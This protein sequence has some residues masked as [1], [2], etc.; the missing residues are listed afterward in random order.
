M[1]TT[2]QNIGTLLL[3]EYDGL[4]RLVLL[5][6]EEQKFI[7]DRRSEPLTELLVKIEDQL[8]HIQQ[9]QSQR[10]AAL[11]KILGEIP[12]TKETGLV[13]QIKQLPPSLVEGNI[14]IAQL[15]ETEIQMVHELTFQN[16]VLLSH[17]V[18]FLE[19]VLAP[20]IDSQRELTT[21]SKD[22]LVQKGNKPQTTFQAVA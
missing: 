10:K 11:H 6:K 1:S 8:A 2:T 17:S 13:A 4:S 15:I 18:H 5:L 7:L 19:A 3:S 20:L 22:G 9:L 12:L 16:H 21:Y 14:K